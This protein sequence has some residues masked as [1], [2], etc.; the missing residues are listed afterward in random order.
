MPLNRRDLLASSVGLAAGLAIGSSF[1]RAASRFGPEEA[2]DFDDTNVKP[3][4]KKI[5]ILILGGTGISGPHLVRLA[6]RRGH[7]VT[8]FNRGMSE[9]RLNDPLPASVERLIGDHDPAKGEGLKALEGKRTWDAVID[10]SGQFPRHVKA[11]CEMLAGRTP[12]YLYVSSIS[13]YKSPVPIDA[14]EDAPL[15]QL[16]DPT[17]EDMGAGFENYGGLKALCEKTAETAM[18][19][20]VAVVRPS[21]I[22]G[23]GDSTDRFTYWPVRIALQGGR[24]L[25]PG[26]GADPIQYIDSRDLA[27]FYLRLAENSTTGVFN[28]AGPAPAL[29]LDELVKVCVK[30]SKLPVEPVWVPNSFL[31][32]KKIGDAGEF[33]IWIPREGEQAG[34][35]RINIDNAVKAGLKLRPVDD[36]VRDTLA[37]W[38]R[39]VE[40][41]IR[42]TNEAKSKAERDKK[43]IPKMAD[44]EKLRAGFDAGKEAEALA[45]WMARAK[46]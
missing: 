23:P 43:P 45:A 16:A 19:G 35:A 34:M 29:R 26:D 20:R 3:A 31:D 41:R 9:K 38:P 12:L 1:V 39:E 15:A 2:P 14:K 44:P 33:T 10:T 6:L 22:S 30:H 7:A 36:T 28:G 18:P 17:V 5:K 13:A 4:D 42:A 27:A 40:R 21:F 25:C 32:E 8:V 24:V 11:S 37:W 46:N